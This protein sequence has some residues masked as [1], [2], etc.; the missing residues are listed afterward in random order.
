MARLPASYRRINKLTRGRMVRMHAAGKSESEIARALGCDRKTVCRWVHRF[1]STASLDDAHR[2]GRPVKQTREML[3]KVEAA[4]RGKKATSVRKV[5]ARLNSKGIEVS[6]MTVQRAAHALN[7]RP[8]ARPRKPALSVDK[9]AARRRFARTQLTRDWT[10]VVAADEATFYLYDTPNR[11]HDLV[12]AKRG[13]AIPAFLRGKSSVKINVF[14][15]I[16][17]G[18]KVVL[19]LF[20][21]RLTADSYVGILRDNL[22]PAATCAYSNNDWAYLHDRSPQHT[23]KAAQAWLDEHV[24]EHLTAVWPP[25]SPDLN[26]MENLWALLRTAAHRDN[27]TTK[28]QLVSAMRAGWRRI[29]NATVTNLFNS[30]PER[31]N[32][33][34][35]AKGGNTRY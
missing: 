2:A 11:R 10:A 17:A 31:L 25:S 29:T 5:A 13:D 34:R 28:E 23:S 33:V 20:E 4:L 32:A 1:A 3:K 14:G 15:A 8:Y 30:M 21:S 6:R 18:G 22:L 7:L 12:W 24:P 19:H 26:V 9:R 35:R 27:P 16:C